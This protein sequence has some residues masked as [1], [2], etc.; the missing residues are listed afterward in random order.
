MKQLFY[1]EGH[2]VKFYDTR[3]EDPKVIIE[4]SSGADVV[5][6][7][8]L[9][10]PEECVQALPGLKMLAVAFTGVDHVSVEACRKQ[11]VTVCNASGYSTINVAEL[12]IGLMLDVLRNVTHLDPITRSG[13]TK[14]GYVGFDLSDKRIGIIGLGEIGLKVAKILKAFGC[15]ILGYNKDRKPTER[16]LV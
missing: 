13:G 11:G 16:E 8:N 10:F 4:R 12:T 6:I 9:P 1:G 14:D 3:N 2:T 7:G 15:S 5:V